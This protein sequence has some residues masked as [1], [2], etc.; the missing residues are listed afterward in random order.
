M[1]GS[2]VGLLS[3]LIALQVLSALPPTVATAILVLSV[4]WSWLAA[5]A[6]SPAYVVITQPSRFQTAWAQRLTDYGVLAHPVVAT[7]SALTI[8]A[9]VAVLIARR[10]VARSV[11]PA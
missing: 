3:P 7:I 4:G 10:A 6:H 2:K 8:A 11:A 5:L 9:L 1:R